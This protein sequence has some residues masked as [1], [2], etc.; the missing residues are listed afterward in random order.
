MWMVY[1]IDYFLTAKGDPKDPKFRDRAMETYF[2]LLE[3]LIAKGVDVNAQNYL[4]ETPLMQA[5][6][7]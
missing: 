3:E 5:C 1:G 7:R 4:G 6:S 2:G